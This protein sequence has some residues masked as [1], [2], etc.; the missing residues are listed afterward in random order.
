MPENRIHTCVAAARGVSVAPL[1]FYYRAPSRRQGLFLGFGG[2]PPDQMH[3]NVRRLA[4]AIHAV[5]N[6]PRD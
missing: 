5:Q 2:T 6:H 4:E 3:A 1:S